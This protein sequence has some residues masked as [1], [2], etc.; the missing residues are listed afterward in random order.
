MPSLGNWISEPLCVIDSLFEKNSTLDVGEVS[1]YFSDKLSDAQQRQQI[2]SVNDL[3]LR[4]LVSGSLVRYRCMVQDLFDPEFF[5]S[6]Y[7]IRDV[8]DPAKQ[9]VCCSLYRDVI[10]CEAHESI[11]Y[12]STKNVT[13]DRQTIYCIPVPG[14]NDWVKRAYAEMSPAFSAAGDGLQTSGQKRSAEDVDNEEMEQSCAAAGA[15]THAGDDTTQEAKRPKTGASQASSSGAASCSPLPELHFPLPSETGV[16]CLVKLYDSSVEVK[17]NDVVE[18][19]GVLS[20]DPSLAVFTS[21]TQS[22]DGE[23]AVVSLCPDEAMEVEH[24]AKNP[25]P[26]LVPRIHAVWIKK[27]DHTNPYLPYELSHGCPVPD[28]TVLADVSG[29]REQL[30]ATLEHALLGDRLAAEFLLCH[31]ASSVYGRQ[32]VVALGKFA[33]NLSRFPRG[34]GCDL[35]QHLSQLLSTLVTKSYVLP[36][37]LAELN[38]RQFV[39]KKDY[40]TNRLRAGLLQLS[41]HTQLVVDETA[42]QPGQ[43]DT[44]GVANMAALGDVVSWQKLDYDFEFHRQPFHSDIAVLVLSEGKSLLKCD[45][46]VPLL[47]DLSADRTVTDT[48]RGIDTFLTPSLLA[49]I[50]TY[51]G[52]VRL[53]RYSVAD[54]VQNVLEEDFVASRREGQDKMSVDDFHSL[55]TLARLLSLTFA[56]TSLTSSTW[57]HA[58]SM[59]ALRKQRIASVV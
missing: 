31:L 43:L 25:P 18:V 54:N 9:R 7:E 11:D 4:Q 33:L 12:E 48:Y 15:D 50:R 16:A 53:L 26:S 17:L 40:A 52:H 34:E 5:L 57:Q 45:C 14:E 42:M 49:S 36:L 23:S 21:S 27:L 59:E 47:L 2:P 37:S 19:V 22:S 39:P 38:S 13:A 41:A 1:R 30:L 51:L 58:K 3:P 35:V 46:Q 55:L 32:N 44:N 29:L 10:S 56:E 6:T 20:V 24:A 28:V 8:E